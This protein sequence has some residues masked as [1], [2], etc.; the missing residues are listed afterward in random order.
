M[1]YYD[2][3]KAKR[4]ICEN[5]VDLVE[6]TLGMYQDW[7]WTAEPIWDSE[8]G[9]RFNGD[10]KTIVIGGIK[11]SKWATPVLNLEY[12]DGNSEYIDCYFEEEK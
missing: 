12:K 11:G 5:K 3:Y 10:E 1:K 2:Y 8:N 9:F 7:Y 4:L 6:A